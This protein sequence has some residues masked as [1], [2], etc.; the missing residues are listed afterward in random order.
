MYKI[1]F[2]WPVSAVHHQ[3]STNMTELSD[4][5]IGGEGRL[6]TLLLLQQNTMLLECFYNMWITTPGNS[7]KKN[8]LIELN[9]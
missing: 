1:S 2:F 7:V 3:E 4:G 5:E 8:M 6:L 9:H